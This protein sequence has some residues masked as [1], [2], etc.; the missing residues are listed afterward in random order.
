LAPAQAQQQQVVPGALIE[1]IQRKQPLAHRHD[2]YEERVNAR[3]LIVSLPGMNGKYHIMQGTDKKF[4]WTS[5]FGYTVAEGA[6]VTRSV[7]M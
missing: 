7:R 6:R 2:L 3:N 1:K 5:S 4:G